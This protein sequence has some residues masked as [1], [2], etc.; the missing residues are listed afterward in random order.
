MNTNFGKAIQD[1]I[2]NTLFLPKHTMQIGGYLRSTNEAHVAAFSGPHLSYLESRNTVWMEHEFGSSK[3]FMSRGILNCD[4][5][6]FIKNHKYIWLYEPYEWIECFDFLKTKLFCNSYYLFRRYSNKINQKRYFLKFGD[7]LLTSHLKWQITRFDE[8]VVFDTAQFGSNYV[9]SELSRTEGGKGLKPLDDKIVMNVLHPKYVANFCE[10]EIG[11]SQAG[12]VLKDG[13]ACSQPSRVWNGNDENVFGSSC[14]YYDPIIGTYCDLEKISLLTMAVGRT[15]RS[16]GYRG[17]FGCDYL[18]NTQNSAIFLSE[19]NLRYTGD[20]ALFNSGNEPESTFAN[21]LHP[22]SLHIMSFL[23][24]RFARFLPTGASSFIEFEHQ[25][26]GDMRAFFE[27][28]SP[29]DPN[30]PTTKFH[31]EMTISKCPHPSYFSQPV[32]LG[33]LNHLV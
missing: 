31:R 15:L 14:T 27:R 19:A 29:I 32:S 26:G 20:V 10:Y 13:V 5:N 6:V 28:G 25:G 11:I 24:N 1:I 2:E 7:D 9:V 21:P 3:E 4:T 12:V 30:E 17:A 8:Q 18:Y 16:F 33:K 22:H 23:D